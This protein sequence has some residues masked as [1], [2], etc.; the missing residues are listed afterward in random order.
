MDEPRDGNRDLRS[1]EL[2]TATQSEDQI[3][4][5]LPR[6]KERMDEA[7]WSKGKQ[8]SFLDALLGKGKK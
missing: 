6:L 4:R 3:A 7:G 1:D 8:Q 5:D 2:P